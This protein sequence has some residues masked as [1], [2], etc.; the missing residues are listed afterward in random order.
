MRSGT[1]VRI[2]S[3]Y[4]SRGIVEHTHTHTKKTQP[5]NTHKN[6]HK[7]VKHGSQKQP[8]C[9]IAIFF[10]IIESYVIYAPKPAFG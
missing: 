7:T 8:Y 3:I 4:E 6:D 2:N 10:I 5:D 9:F 1:K